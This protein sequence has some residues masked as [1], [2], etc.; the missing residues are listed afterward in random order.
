MVHAVQRNSSY[1]NAMSTTGTRARVEDKSP[2][3]G[4]CPLCI[5]ECMVLCNVSLSAFRGREALYPDPREFG[6][7]TA[8][9]L[10]DYGLDWS[11]FNIK[12]RLRSP[13][14]KNSEWDAFENVDVSTTTAGIPL[15][16]PVL[17]GA[18]G[19][20]EVARVNWESLAI[21]SAISGIAIG[22][23]ENVCGMDPEAKFTN[24]LVSESPE[25]KRRV[26]AFRRFWDGKHGDVIVQTNVEDRKMGVDIYALSKLEV[27]I[28]ERKWGQ[29]AKAIGGEIRTS[30][31]ERAIMLKRRG[32]IV[33][34]DPE[35]RIVQEAYRSGVIRSF[36]RHSRIEIP[37]EKNFIEDIENLREHGAKKIGLKTGA[38]CAE[39]VAFT[40]K[41]ASE[42]KVDYLVFDGAGGGTGMSPVPMMNEQGTPTVYL[43]AQVIK[44]AEILKKKGRHIPDI[45][46][47]GGFIDETQMFKAIALSNFGDGPYVKAIL[48]GRAPLT[49]TMKSRFFAE[50]AQKG[51]LPKSF[52]DSFGDSPAKFFITA[53]QLKE[54][55]GEKFREIPWGAV[56]LYTYLERI[57]VGLQQIITGVRKIHLSQINRDDL[58]SLTERAYRATGIPLPE[59]ECDIMEKLLD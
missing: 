38:Y 30:N 43:E 46:M 55:Y 26:E 17:I 11:H 19:S 47:A 54:K 14:S 42:A 52:A 2:S 48:M 5:T 22:I 49:A 28:I 4:L 25:L 18:Y 37:E 31:L 8:S 7:S 20:T 53:P 58:I 36:E 10:K 13:V 40:M 1:L 6:K 59:E 50:L 24:N 45:I 56:G 33:I 21:G 44:C 39:D 34:P 9:S 12:A 27:N 3:S 23:G 29:G 41:V 15:K 32:Y 51:Q 57:K 16:I 35:S